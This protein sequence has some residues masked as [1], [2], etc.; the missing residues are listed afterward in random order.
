MNGTPRRPSRR[1]YTGLDW[2]SET[3][4]YLDGAPKIKVN[5]QQNKSVV[6]GL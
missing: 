4:E 1:L 3:Q 6:S 2:P 5:K